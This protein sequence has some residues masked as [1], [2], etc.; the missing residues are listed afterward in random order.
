MKQLIHAGTLTLLFSGMFGLTLTAM[1][2]PLAGSPYYSDVA[3][4]YVQDATSDGM[5]NVNMVLCIMNAMSPSEML[6]KKGVL[7]AATGIT[8][9]K[10]IALVDKNKCDSKTRASAS[11]SASSETGATSTPNYMTATVDITRG[12]SASDPM[13]GKIWMTLAES[14]RTMSVSIKLSATTAPATLPPYGRLRLD[15]VGYPVGQTVLQ[16]NGFIDTNGGVLSHVENGANSSNVS[17]ALNAVDVNTGNGVLRATLNDGGSPHTVNYTFAYSSAAFAR[18]DGLSGDLCFDRS[19]ANA[20]RSVWRYG[21]YDATSGARV[22]QAHPGFPLTATAGS[23]LTGVTAGQKVFGYASYWG[24]NFGG[25]DPSLVPGLP[26]GQITAVTG[27]TDGRPNQTTTYNLYKSSGKLINWQRHSTTLGAISG[28]PFNMFG[29]GCK[30]VN[31]GNGS[32]PSPQNSPSGSSCAGNGQANSAPYNFDFRNWVV[33]WNSNLVMT[34]GGVPVTGNFEVIG[35]QDCTSNNCLMTTF[36][37]PVPAQQGFKQMPI[38]AWSEALGSL[39]IPLPTGNTMGMN[40]SLANNH[41]NADDVYYFSQSTVLPSVSNALTLYCLSNCPTNASL[42]AAAAD[43]TPFLVSPFAT[44]TDR[45]WGSGTAEKT[46]TFG[47]NGLRDDTNSPVLV[48]A[49]LPNPMWQGGINSG[50][51]FTLDLVKS[52]SSCLSTDAYCEP[53]A[54]PDYYTYQTGTNQ[55]NQTMWLTTAAGSPVSF[56]PPQIASFTVPSGGAYGSWAGKAIQLQFNGFGN[57]NGIPG[58]CIDPQTNA[59]ASC[60][61]STRF[62]PAFALAD[63]SA[64]NLGGQA[65]LTRAL[66]SELRL[67]SLA[68]GALSTTGVTATLP[69]ELPHN[70]TVLSDPSYIG[71]APQVLGAPSV[72]DGVLQ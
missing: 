28:V 7:D 53:S 66:D 60:G 6:T 36:Q 20:K 43:I 1:S 37:S 30:L 44:P 41:S 59:V 34:R 50:R 35:M 13:V 70:P 33:Q 18:N 25:M 26:D 72:I 54:P 49:A 63:G 57:L 68:C 17:L 5:S 39:T 55:W 29:E 67:S 10:Y 62:V 3:N 16:F 56:D 27:I 9:V 58:N 31:G 45:Q 23:G 15:Y 47:T 8:E 64:L 21:V 32:G 40:P 65:V 38:N 46:Y 61:P 24:V 69:T 14:G 4:E 48:T 19:K 12:N 52:G 51:M 71:T 2:A 42:A 22:D 11:N